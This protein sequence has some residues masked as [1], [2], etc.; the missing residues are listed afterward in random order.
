MNQTPQSLWMDGKMLED[1][2]AQYKKKEINC[3]GLH[4]SKLCL[5]NWRQGSTDISHLP[6]KIYQIL[7][8]NCCNFIVIYCDNP[9]FVTLW[10]GSVSN[11]T[12]TV[13]VL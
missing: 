4:T 1:P 13:N 8:K 10:V 9:T 2:P 7:H 3:K 12:S 5:V 6:L 11:L